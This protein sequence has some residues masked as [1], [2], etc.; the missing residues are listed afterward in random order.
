M[1]DKDIP[2]NQVRL[3]F[4]LIASNYV[5]TPGNGGQGCSARTGQRFHTIVI[6]SS[7]AYIT[8]VGQL[9]PKK[10]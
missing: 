10:Q 9:P 7:H 4:T 1:V 6:A 3:L 2:L 5:C 8:R